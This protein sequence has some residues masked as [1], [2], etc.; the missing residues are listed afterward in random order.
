[1]VQAIVQRETSDLP[2][3]AALEEVE[4]RL[5]ARLRVPQ[6]V[7]E[8]LRGPWTQVLAAEYRLS[9]EGS[10]GWHARVRAMDELLWSVEPKSSP[11]GRKRLATVLPDLVEA[12]ADGLE[13]AGVALEERSAFLSE[14]VD[15]HAQAMKAGLRGLALVPAAAVEPAA[16]SR[17][18]AAATFDAGARRVEEIR[19]LNAGDAPADA[20]DDVVA[21]LRIGA[22]VELARGGRAAARKRLA[23]ASPITGAL[24]LVGLSPAS[25]GVA[26]SP[27]ALA[28]K[29][30]RGEARLVDATP[31]VD[32]S[33]LAIAS[34]PEPQG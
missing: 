14:L 5:R 19:L 24:L 26:I 2:R 3:R 25:I 11:E 6:P 23:W 17:A 29:L 1:M 20:H 9:G 12:I 8:M 4:R 33:M 18:F 10:Q 13:L 27:E 22:W 28:E 32:R 16:Q 30:R 15:C 21:R 7:R 31:L 34:R